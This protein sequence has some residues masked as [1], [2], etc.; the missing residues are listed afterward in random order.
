MCYS[1]ERVRKEFISVCAAAGVTITQ[2][3]E[4]NNRLR[5]C[6]G[7]VAS[8]ANTHAIKRIEFSGQFLRQGANESIHE[9]IL[10]EAA[11]AIVLARTKEAHHHDTY[12]KRVCAE[13]GAKANEPVFNAK[14]DA[15]ASERYK[16]Q[17]FCPT[18]N[19]VL[20]GGYHRMCK[21]L[22]HI[23][24]CTCTKCG[25]GNLKVIQNW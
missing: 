2:P 20:D 3:I 11:H 18:C 5:T 1:I 10:H 12:F 4:V 19:R 22:S 25:K 13:I 8:D 14:Y 7:R 16:Y 24:Y 17:I 6:L 21:T 15:P 23:D 9:V